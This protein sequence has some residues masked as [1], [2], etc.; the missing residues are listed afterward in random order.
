MHVKSLEPVMKRVLRLSRR[1]W[2]WSRSSGLWR[3]VLLWSDTLKMEAVSSSDTLVSFT[4]LQG[5]TTQKT[6]TWT[7]NGNPDK[8]TELNHGI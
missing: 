3:R 5:V 7:N 8:Q 6:S 4:A 1:W 2:F